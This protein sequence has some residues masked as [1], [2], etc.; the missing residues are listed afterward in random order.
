[1]NLLIAHISKLSLHAVFLIFSDLRK[2]YAGKWCNMQDLPGDNKRAFMFPTIIKYSIT[3]QGRV[4]FLKTK[5]A[6]QHE[7]G[8]G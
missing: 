4:T 5:K 7:T 2:A 3:N 8:F 6:H 1:M